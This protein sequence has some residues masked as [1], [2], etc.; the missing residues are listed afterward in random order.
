MLASDLPAWLVR[1]SALVLGATFGSF[2]NVA[3]HR[4]PRDM[5]VVSPPSH[6]PACGA[7][8]PA[9]R[10]VPILS[11]VLQRGRAA[12]CGAPMTPRYVL[13]EVIS[14]VL[15]LAIAER[16]IVAAE[17]DEALSSVAIEAALWFAFA[18]ALLIATFADLEWM[19]IPDEVSLGGTALGLATAMF[20]DVPLEE[21]ALGAGGGFLV[22]RGWE[23]LTG[24]RG[25]GEGDP[26][27]A[28]LIGAF[29]GWRGV[30]FAVIAG[31]FQGIIGY[32]IARAT[33]T[34]I[35]PDLSSPGVLSRMQR[36]SLRARS[37][38][39]DRRR[40]LAKRYERI[41]VDEG[42]SARMVPFG[43]FLA[44]G[45]LEFLF[46]GDVIIEWYLALFA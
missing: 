27:L 6:C 26:K 32:V 34:R 46:F 28:M 10:N 36:A 15:A 43:P 4:W 20:R 19:E 44:L 33:G 8:I 38:I 25:M 5:S 3:I 11:Y 40:R 24:Q 29:L 14:G 18:G 2:F 41:D 16:T 12:C 45:A 39:R 13:V 21:I 30:L 42:T 37:A 23:R 7:A 31:S 22:V 9:W 17:R 35:G 1:V